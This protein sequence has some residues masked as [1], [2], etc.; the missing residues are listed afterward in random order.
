MQ[1]RPLP[2]A[3]IATF[4][5]LLAAACGASTPTPQR[6]PSGLTSYGSAVWNLEAL[7]HDT[8]GKREVWEEYGKTNIPD[9]TT[10]F[11]D[12]ARSVP[13]VYTFANAHHSTFRPLRTK[14]PPGIAD[15]VTGSDVPL[16]INGSYISCGGDLWL[17]EHSG[18]ALPGGDL[19][20][21]KPHHG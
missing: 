2:L 21:A 12:L 6:P 18:Q 11:L 8:F 10:Q 3:V 14:H 13:Y 1:M 20:C 7:L 4:V 15:Y 5:V 16:M 9:F 19:S 17:Y